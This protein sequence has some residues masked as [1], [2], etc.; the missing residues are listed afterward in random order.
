MLRIGFQTKTPRGRGNDT[1]LQYRLNE[2]CAIGP[3]S[4]HTDG[5]WSIL[6]KRILY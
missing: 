4:C 1:E 6:Y 2:R 3:I 5:H